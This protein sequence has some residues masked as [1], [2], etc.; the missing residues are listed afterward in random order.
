MKKIIQRLTV[1]FVGFPALLTV[2]M[3]LPQFNHLVLNLVIIAFSILGAVELRNILTHKNLTISV[4]EAALLGGISPI[5]WTVVVTLG[6]SGMNVVPGAFILGASWLLISGIFT[7]GEK[8]DS[9]IGRVAAGFAVMI[10]P[11]LFMAWV[12]QMAMFP[13]AGFVILVFFL[14]SLLNDAIAWATG[15]LFGKNNRGFV[16]ASPNKSIAGFAG[17]LAASVGAG[18]IAVVTLPALFTSAVLPSPLAGALLGLGAGAAATLGDLGESA[19]KRSAGV[20]DSGSLIMGRGG[21]LDSID[22]VALA[23]PVYYM[24]YRLLFLA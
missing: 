21:A 20:K 8:L 1:F 24:L 18:I 6:I 17:G 9:Y 4:P 3:L 14:M 7:S 10:Y 16:A 11:G 13:D 19:I 15:V 5:A 12:I 22:S 2:V 23:A